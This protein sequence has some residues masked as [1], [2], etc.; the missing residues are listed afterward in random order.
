MMRLNNYREPVNE[1]SGETHRSGA[2]PVDNKGSARGEPPK[3][4]APAEPENSDPNNL[5]NFTLEDIPSRMILIDQK[6]SEET[7]MVVYH[8]G[9]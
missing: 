2:A 5:D 4:A 8:H 3:P 7:H 9:K 6:V 1:G